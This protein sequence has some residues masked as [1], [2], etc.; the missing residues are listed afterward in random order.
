MK[1]KIALWGVMCIAATPVIYCFNR[2]DFHNEV[3]PN[4]PM[5]PIVS[6]NNIYNKHKKQSK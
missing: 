3:P 6:N 2:R 4:S 1:S 5:F